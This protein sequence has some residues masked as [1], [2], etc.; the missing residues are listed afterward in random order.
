[1]SAE[2][3]AMTRTWLGQKCSAL[4]TDVVNVLCTW[5]A[6]QRLHNCLE[7]LLEPVTSHGRGTAHDQ[8]LLI[9]NG[10]DKK[11]AYRVT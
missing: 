6:Q 4:T 11:T 9:A 2:H 10:H 8:Q 5:A 3:R 7:H 1:M